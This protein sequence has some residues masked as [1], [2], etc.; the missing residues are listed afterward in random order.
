[1]DYLV[2]RVKVDKWNEL[3]IWCIQEIKDMTRN[4]LVGKVKQN[5]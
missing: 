5:F 4:G 1:M 2:E 3:R